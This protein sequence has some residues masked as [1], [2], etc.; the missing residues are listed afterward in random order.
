[1]VRD[2]RTAAVSWQLDF[3]VA[4]NGHFGALRCS[5]YSKVKSRLRAG[6]VDQCNG[7][8]WHFF[9]EPSF[10]RKRRELGA[11]RTSSTVAS[12]VSVYESTT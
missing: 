1:M 8:N 4:A 5:I 2:V 10:A 7:R 3:A 12:T 6:F 11:T 9:P